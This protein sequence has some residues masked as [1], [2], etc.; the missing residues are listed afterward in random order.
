[1]RN[2][3]SSFVRKNLR[4]NTLGDIYFQ[5]NFNTCLIGVHVSTYDV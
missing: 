4:V 2:K 1:M 5:R 3:E